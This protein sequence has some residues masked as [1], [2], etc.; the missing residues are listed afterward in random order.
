MITRIKARN[1]LS[2]RD[3]DLRLGPRNVLV[4]PNMSGKSN[5]IDLCNFLTTMATERPG[6][7]TAVL[8][9]GGFSE[10][11]WKGGDDKQV[12]LA[13]TVE[14]P[15]VEDQ[16]KPQVYEYALSL[17]EAPGGNCIVE[18]EKLTILVDGEEPRT[19]YEIGFG[20]QGVVEEQ[21]Q[22][23]PI[24]LAHWSTALESVGLP[25][26]E[27]D[28]FRSIVASWRFYQLIPALMRQEN[29]PS[30]EPFLKQHGENFSSWITTLQT[31]PEEFRQVR[32][33]VCDALPDLAEIII[34]PTQASRIVLSTH[35]KY[36]RRATS[37]SRMSDGELAFLALVSLI[38]APLEL[39]ASLY[40]IEEPENYLHPY[41][42]ETLVELLTQRQ[43]A[44]GE[45]SGQIIATTHS[46][47]LVDKLNADDL[48]VTEKLNGE[49][50]FRSPS[51]SQHLKE[52]L[53]RAELGLGDL[54]YSGALGGA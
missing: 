46:P 54:W 26:V 41:L 24:N 19:I 37:I 47:Y 3:I 22:L 32:Q 48:I 16:P 6:L 14:L 1:F 53:A 33:A 51:S 27:A 2:L 36:L 39:G 43:A 42:L 44:L 38:F 31:H 50:K 12:S 25:N 13:I 11:I 45:Q 30:P 28:R 52:L 15:R 9:R 49:T 21:G 18:S 7:H 8:Q 35:E 20:R 17:I 23:R 40:C 5:L 34:Q 10:L 4:G 29:T